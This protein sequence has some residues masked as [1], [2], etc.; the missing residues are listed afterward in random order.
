MTTTPDKPT[1]VPMPS[2]AMDNKKQNKGP[3]QGQMMQNQEQSEVV[4]PQEDAQR[5]NGPLAI[6]VPAEGIELR[7][8]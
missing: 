2:E 3:H 4:V 1:T 7:K 8:K 6:G 5:N